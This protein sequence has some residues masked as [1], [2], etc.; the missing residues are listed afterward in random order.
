MCMHAHVCMYT[1]GDYGERYGRIDKP[2]IGCI[3]GVRL[4]EMM[5]WGL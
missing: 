5:G 1:S 4:E 3:S 2:V